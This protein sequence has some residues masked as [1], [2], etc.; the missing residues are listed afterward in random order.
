MAVGWQGWRELRECRVGCVGCVAGRRDTGALLPSPDAKRCVQRAH[1]LVGTPQA[2]G[3]TPLS[4]Q[5]E[6]ERVGGSCALIPCDSCCPPATSTA[7]APFGHDHSAGDMPYQENGIGRTLRM[8]PRRRRQR[9]HCNGH[10]Y[11]M[12]FAS[13]ER[14]EG[15]DCNVLPQLALV[16]EKMTH[17]RRSFV[18][19]RRGPFFQYSRCSP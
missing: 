17:G 10:F 18:E 1:V 14:S 19:V 3:K 16:E 9:E 4:W 13:A 15:A 2:S 5:V 8:R 12:V 11:C 7:S 6:R